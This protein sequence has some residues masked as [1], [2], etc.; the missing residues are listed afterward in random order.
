ME[1]V[2]KLIAAAGY[3]S[4]RK[5]E[6]LIAAGK[7]T[8]NGKVA[9]LGD[10]A[11]EQD[12]ILVEGKPLQ[13]ER[14]V[15]LLFHKPVGCVTAVTDTREKTV[16]DYIKV[17]ERV[18]PIGRLDKETS[19]LL[20]LT[21]DGALANRI[22][23]PRYE[24]EKTYKVRLDRSIRDSELKKA[25]RGVSLEDGPSAA[26]KATRI[27]DAELEFT[28]HEGRNRIVRRIF[29]ALGFTVVALQRVRIGTLALGKLR[30]GEYAFVTRGK[31][32]QAVFL[33]S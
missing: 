8:V 23:H 17:K 14:L 22:M 33:A 18:Y 19:G 6:E 5:A 29:E 15:Y 12:A 21:N 13:R 26:A 16:M 30:P 24:V 4:R 25:M 27:G 3:C 9:K 28:I 7:V 11:T 10:T 32:E 1:R 31:I 2:Q 20:I